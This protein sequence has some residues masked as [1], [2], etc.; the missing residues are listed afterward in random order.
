MWKETLMSGGASFTPL[1][2]V[3]E[4]ENAVYSQALRKKSMLANGDNSQYIEQL[5]SDQE[6]KSPAVM[7][8][9]KPLESLSKL[10]S[11]EEE[12]PPTKVTGG[13]SDNK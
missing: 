9:K 4:E 11:E 2:N 6:K 12:N 3:D 10:Y 13:N 1:L 8:K 7:P 5:H